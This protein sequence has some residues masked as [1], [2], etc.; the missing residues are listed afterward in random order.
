[1]FLGLILTGL[2]IGRM[3]A[4]CVIKPRD[5]IAET[6]GQRPVPIALKPAGL[7]L[8]QEVPDDRRSNCKRAPWCGVMTC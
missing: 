1:M 2:A 3:V 5:S 8:R 7:R 6:H 4:K